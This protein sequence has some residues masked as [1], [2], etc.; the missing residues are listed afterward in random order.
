MD[1]G[2]GLMLVGFGECLMAGIVAGPLASRIPEWLGWALFG[3]AFTTV[4]WGSVLIWQGHETFPD[5][6]RST[7]WAVDQRREM[8]ENPDHPIYKWYWA[9]TMGFKGVTKYQ[10][11]VALDKVHRTYEIEF[12]T[13]AYKSPLLYL[14]LGL[15]VIACVAV[16]RLTISR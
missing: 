7:K 8:T 5:W 2:F 14:L 16:L 11:Q 4:M 13:T 6:L 1:S 10:H 15:Q 12:R 3:F 9:D